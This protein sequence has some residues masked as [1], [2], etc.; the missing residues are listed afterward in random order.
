MHTRLIYLTM[1][2]FQVLLS[3]QINNMCSFVLPRKQKCMF[4]TLNG[5]RLT[6]NV[7]KHSQWMRSFAVGQLYKDMYV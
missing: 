7:W 1:Q 6:D 2:Y 3:I 5:Q 4:I